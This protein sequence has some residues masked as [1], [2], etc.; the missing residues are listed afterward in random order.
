MTN[1]LEHGCFP[2]GRPNLVRPMRRPVGPP[3]ALVVGVFPSAFHVTWSPPERLRSEAPE[4][5][6]ISSLAVDVEPVV[7]WD[8][9]DPSPEAL[10][11]EWKVAV[12]FDP[13]RQGDVRVGTN[14][15]SGAG[16][17][18]TVLEPLGLAPGDVAFTDA[19][20]WYVVKGSRRGSQGAAVRER[21][22]P[23]ADAME[24]VAGDLPERPSPSGLVALASTGER[25]D[26]LR[27]EII[28]AEA[29]LIITLGQEALDAVRG[30]ADVAAG[31]QA[32]LAA[33]G[34]GTRGKL[35]IADITFDVLPLV[36]PG[37]ARQ[38]THEKWREALDTWMVDA[39]E[40]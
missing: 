1:D 28:D 35:S 11:A 7:F 36:H 21:F 40:G 18:T 23:L 29:P 30:V 3:T 39:V 6:P 5:Y 15:P 25:R 38:T 37:F 4:D 26:S 31:M 12:G 20:P 24:A 9:V 8:G 33:K 14:G 19:V 2:F 27:A 13:E 17:L 16:L 22:N 34:Y 32:K 10:L